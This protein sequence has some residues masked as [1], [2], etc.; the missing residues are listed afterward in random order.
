MLCAAFYR[1]ENRFRGS[2]VVQD[3]KSG[4]VY[5]VALLPVND[6]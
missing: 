2:D 1:P 4:F 3:Y 5:T 6:L